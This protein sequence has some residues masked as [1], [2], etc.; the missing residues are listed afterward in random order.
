MPPSEF[1]FQQQKKTRDIISQRRM[2]SSRMRTTLS[3]PYR[4][5]VGVGEG[6]R[7]SLSR[8][9]RNTDSPRTE[10]PPQRDPLDRDPP[11][12]TQRPPRQRPSQHRDPLDRDSSPRQRPPL[13]SDPPD[14]DPPDRDPPDS[15]KSFPKEINVHKVMQNIRNVYFHRFLNETAPLGDAVV[16]LPTYNN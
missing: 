3:L 5:G 10:T 8:S 6:G 14:T 1:P 2:H 4:G 7:G 16:S 12:H 11:P 13:D 9:L 15:L